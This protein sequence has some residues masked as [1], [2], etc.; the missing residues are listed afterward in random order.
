MHNTG[1]SKQ[2]DHEKT[3]FKAEMDKLESFVTSV[4]PYSCNHEAFP[5]V[6]VLFQTIHSN[7]IKEKDKEIKRLHTEI[8]NLKNEKKV[9]KKKKGCNIS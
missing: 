8:E 5:G 9:K 7:M 3:K 2:Y 6:N 1:N 4:E